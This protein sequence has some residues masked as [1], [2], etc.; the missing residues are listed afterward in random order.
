VESVKAASGVYAPADLEVVEVNE[1]LDAEPELVNSSCY[2]KALSVE[3]SA[4][5]NANLL[6]S[7]FEIRAGLPL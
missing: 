4:N 5:S 2:D 1:A 6:A 3:P 7:V